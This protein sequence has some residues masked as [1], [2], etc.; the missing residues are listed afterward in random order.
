M[1]NKIILIII[2][3]LAL[4]T[5]CE[6]PEVEVF[7]SPQINILSTQVQSENTCL[8]EL[9]IKKGHGATLSDITLQFTDISE[10]SA[11]D[12]IVKYDLEDS[13]EYTKT[14]TITVPSSNHDYRVKAF[15]KSSKNTYKSNVSIVYFSKNYNDLN[16]GI[17]YIDL[18]NNPEND[19]YLDKENNIGLC[20]PRGSFFLLDLTLSK[21][22]PKTS[23]YILKLNDTI[24]ISFTVSPL[25]YTGNKEHIEVNIPEDLPAGDYTVC[26]YLYGNRYEALSKLR[27][28]PGKAIAYDIPEDPIREIY[29]Y[30]DVIGNSFIINN[31]IYFIYTLDPGLNCHGFVSC[32]NID[33][34]TWERKKDINIFGAT[35]YNSWISNCSFKYNDKQY[36]IAESFYGDTSSVNNMCIIEYN[37]KLDSWKNITT[38]PG[39]GTQELAAFQVNGC[40]YMG[41]GRSMGNQM[42][43]FWEYSFAQKKWTQ[44]N[45]IPGSL[46]GVIISSCSSLNEGYVLSEYRELWKYTSNNDT[47]TKISVLRQGPYSRN[48]TKIH[49]NNG[50][51]Y[52]SGGLTYASLVT[53][54]T[55]TW[56]Y[57]ISTNKWRLM[58]LTTNGIKSPTFFY[59]NKI[60][61]AIQRKYNYN[62]DPYI[63]E[64]TL[65]Y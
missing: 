50:K 15:L 65:E 30:L 19:Y 4:F 25:Y 53:Y 2:L 17:K 54:L 14:Y 16:T 6:Q 59:N 24:P 55:D 58:C 1:E 62:S 31:K 23:P 18:Y 64:I 3:I 13:V 40:V 47:W 32:F 33:T 5:S 43:D 42:T 61:A 8:I 38:Y 22:I 41:G 57:N 39:E 48:E 9:K 49:Y 29:H 12:Y 63:Y 60:I 46:N 52:L 35:S 44:K 56:E 36:I 26:L 11:D 21:N 51:I 7:V 10:T 27:V 28:L 37:D 45:D 20:L 34:R